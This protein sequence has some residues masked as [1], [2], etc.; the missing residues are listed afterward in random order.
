MQN[1][2]LVSS[3]N[4]LFDKIPDDLFS[5]LSRKYKTIY[6]FSLICLYRLLR[7]YKTD[8]KKTDYVN[9]L[10]SQ[11]VELMDLFSVETDQLDDKDEDEKVEPD[12]S[13][14]SLDNETALGAKVNYVV[15]KL[16]RCGWFI[17][18]KN[19]KTGVEYIFIPA[20]SI[21][22][23]KLIND[24]TSDSGSYLPLVHQTYAELK[25]ED[26][27]EDDY[28]YRALQN[29]RSSADTLEMSV[30]LLRQQICV[31]GNRLTSVLDPNVALKQHFDEYRVDI[32]ER[33]Y[34]PMK[35][36]DSLGLYSQPTIEILTRWLRSERIITLLVREA[37]AE[38]ANRQTDESVLASDIIKLIQDII[39]IFS[40]LSKDFDAIDSANANYTEAVQRKV[41]YLSATDK[42]VKGKI[43]RIILALATEIKNNPALRY[44]E[45]PTLEK[46]TDSIS[47]FRQGMVDSQSLSM[48]F[49]RKEI[50]ECEPLPLEDDF[51]PE[52]Q[53]M[54]MNDLLDNELNRFSDRT[55]IEFIEDNMKGREQIQTT[56]IPLEN[57]DHLVL[58]ILGI[59]KAKLGL[60]PYDAIE[61]KDRIEYEGYYMPLYEFRRNNKKEAR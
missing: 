52:D 36:F 26:E 1:E 46:A 8:I 29:A 42:T 32:S 24:L 38:P 21:Q 17:I 16:A 59:L 19:P 41:N 10:K 39:D 27:K 37:K 56:D 18:S 3:L 54:M 15:R 30:T 53:A 35:T 28:M 25:M 34:H 13:I 44:E 61:I 23:L 60:I 50:E 7:L 11:G 57:T 55:I 9:L 48:P 49:N 51:L 58:M 5:P 2:R 33:Y 20:Y 31:F 45:M 4:R 47:F 40:R 22:M 43:D 12:S 14:A 6:A